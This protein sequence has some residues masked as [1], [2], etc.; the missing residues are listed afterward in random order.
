MKYLR[1]YRLFEESPW[2]ADG[3]YQ[4]EE[5]SVRKRVQ[6]KIKEVDQIKQ[7]IEDILLPI[8]DMGYRGISVTDNTTYS[9][10]FYKSPTQFTIRIVTYTDKPLLVNFKVKDE[11]DRMVYYLKSIGIYDI[12]VQFVETTPPQKRGYRSITKVTY[13]RFSNIVEPHFT[14]KP[15]SVFSVCNLLFIAEVKS[16]NTD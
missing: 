4:H 10:P 3:T 15:K 6:D 11:F 14:S 8:Y 12:T 1:N 9:G 5:D 16:E 2:K 13:D 7:T